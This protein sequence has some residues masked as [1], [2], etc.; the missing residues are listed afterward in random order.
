ML[1]SQYKLAT[2]RSTE[3]LR[4]EIPKFGI[5]QIGIPIFWLSRHWNF[6][7]KSNRNLRNQ[8]W[9]WNSAYDGGPRN[10]NQKL[11]FP[12]KSPP[13][14][15]LPPWPCQESFLD[16]SSRIP[17]H[18]AL[19]LSLVTHFILDGA[20]ICLLST[21]FLSSCCYHFILVVRILLFLSL[22]SCNESLNVHFFEQCI[23]L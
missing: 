10:W 8:T 20:G 22:V 11:E 1:W 4:K 15:F 7:K 17:F 3:F 13:T 14:S 23:T 19:F 2:I 9:N 12:T 5:S 21:T 6:K 16:A 18:V